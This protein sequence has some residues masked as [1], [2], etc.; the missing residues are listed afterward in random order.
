MRVAVVGA[1]LAGLGV[2]YFLIQKGHSVTLFDELGVGSGASGIPI[3]LCHPYVGRSGKPSK[4]SD[5][6]MT[7][8]R[9]LIDKVEKTSGKKLADRSGILR[10]DWN[11][12]QWYPDLEKVGEG[13]CIKSG[14]T[15]YM[16]EYVKALY[17]SFNNVELVIKKVSFEEEL[18]DF[19]RVIF[20]SGAGIKPF[21]LDVTFVKGQVVIGVCKNPPEKTI[22]KAYGHMSPL[23]DGRVQIGSTYEHHYVSSAP[24]QEVALRELQPKMNALLSKEDEFVIEGCFSGIRVC[25]KGGYLPI[26][27][28]LNEK[29]FVFTGLGS[30]GLLYHAYYGRHLANMIT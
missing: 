8:T 29:V 1:G 12:I 30:R 25:V 6:A 15:V 16:R 19:D 13:V 4:F 17:D 27:K 3:G 10:V 26:I 22:M 7:A 5:D 28:Q 23:R 24:D 18:K 2:T 11:P 21:C 9:E 14:M 20:A